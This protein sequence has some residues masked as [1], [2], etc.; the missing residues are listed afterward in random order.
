MEACLNHLERR[1]L[2]AAD[3]PLNHWGSDID[4]SGVDSLTSH[5]FIASGVAM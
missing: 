1:A 3:G 5:Q 2:N 4:K